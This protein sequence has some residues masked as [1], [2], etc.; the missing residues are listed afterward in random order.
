MKEQITREKWLTTYF[1]AIYDTQNASMVA[2]NILKQYSSL[3]EIYSME[4]ITEFISLLVNYK[5]YLSWSIEA[6]NE[7]YQRR[8][9]MGSIDETPLTINRLQVLDHLGN[10][11]SGVVVNL[12]NDLTY[13]KNTIRTSN[14]H[15]MLI[16]QERDQIQREER[17]ATVER[18]R[19]LWE[20][21][22]VGVLELI[23]VAIGFGIALLTQ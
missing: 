16:R 1:D 12:K 8:I 18:K 9:N 21:G 6:Q 4:T 10:L 22:F 14:H 23:M 20:Y 19:Q 5:L 2:Y 7:L 11:I 15:K 17:S 3:D 13:I